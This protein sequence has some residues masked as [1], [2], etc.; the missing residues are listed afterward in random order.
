[1]LWL[2]FVSCKL[3]WIDNIYDSDDL[4]LTQ[5]IL[6]CTTGVNTEDEDLEDEENDENYK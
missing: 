5:M 6:Q 2:P 1:M 3:I 4:S